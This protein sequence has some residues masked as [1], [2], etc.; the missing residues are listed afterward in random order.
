MNQ[1]SRLYR[2]IDVLFLEL[3]RFSI[4]KISCLSHTPSS[5]EWCALY[6]LAKKQALIGITFYGIQKLSDQIQLQNLPD[7]LKIKWIGMGLAIHRKNELINR[8]CVELQETLT[9]NGIR[10][11]IMKGQGNSALYDKFESISENKNLKLETVPL[12][13]FR[14]PGDID[15]F[16]EGGREKVL[17]YVDSF[18]VQILY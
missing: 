5:E 14:Q 8:R 10:S 11:Y 16:L 13:M 9:K 12:S 6:E 4:G 2:D 7:A 3:V 15:V 17:E 18:L 1:S